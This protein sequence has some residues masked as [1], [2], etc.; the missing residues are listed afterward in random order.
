MLSLPLSTLDVA[1]AAAALSCA[2]FTASVSASPAAMSDTLLPPLFRPSLVRLTGL[3]AL[4]L[5]TVSPLSVR[6]LPPTV[7]LSKETSSEVATVMFLPLRLTLTFLPSLKVTVSPA[8]IFSDEVS[9]LAFRFQPLSAVS[10]TAA[11]AS[12]TLSLPVPPMSVVVTLPLSLAALPPSKFARLAW[13]AF[14]C[15]SLAA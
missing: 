3:P 2:T 5:P 15:S 11:M 7:T 1:F 4:P 10:F 13:V 14:N 8:P 9:S 6:T 12:W